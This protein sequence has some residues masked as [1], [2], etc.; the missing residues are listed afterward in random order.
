MQKNGSASTFE[1][2]VDALKESLRNLVDTGSER[3]GVLKNKAIDV[4]D[5]V[6]ESGGKA[7][8]RT[9]SLI[10]QHPIIALGVA[11]GVGYLA[12]RMMRK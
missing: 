9:T 12:V 5:T 8:D 6:F 2:R 10:K 11:F 4:K 1:H 3:A 7:L